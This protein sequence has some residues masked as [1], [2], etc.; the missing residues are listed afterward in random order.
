MVVVAYAFN[1]CSC[2]LRQKDDH[3]FKASLGNRVHFRIASL[4]TETSERIKGKLR[5]KWGKK[6]KGRQERG[7]GKRRK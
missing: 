5:R 6:R 2:G 1:S 7:E 4:A 3:E